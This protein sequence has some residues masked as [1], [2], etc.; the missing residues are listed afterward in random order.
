MDIAEDG[1]E[2]ADQDDRGGGTPQYRH[3]VRFYEPP[4]AGWPEVKYIVL[5]PPGEHGEATLAWRAAFAR[6][7]SIPDFNL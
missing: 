5:P 7:M 6:A 3:P 1:G 2:M 4:K